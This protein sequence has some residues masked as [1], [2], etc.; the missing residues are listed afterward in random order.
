VVFVFVVFH[1]FPPYLCGGAPARWDVRSLSRSCCSAWPVP[2]GCYGVTPLVVGGWGERKPCVCRMS[3]AMVSAAMNAVQ[4][5][6]ESHVRCHTAVFPMSHRNGMAT[7][8][9]TRRGIS[10]VAAVVIVSPRR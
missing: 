8:R 5:A 2:C 3:T 4:N 9:M 6:A 7:P 1:V 10:V